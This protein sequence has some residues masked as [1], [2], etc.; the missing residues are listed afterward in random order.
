MILAATSQVA[1]GCGCGPA[2]GRGCGSAS[3]QG[4]KDCDASQNDIVAPTDHQ[5][6]PLSSRKNDR[7][8][9]RVKKVIVTSTLSFLELDTLFCQT[10]P[11]DAGVVDPRF[12][13][14]RVDFFKS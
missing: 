1:T 3:G 5:H 10:H 8:K 9:P 12:V 7:N 4:T 2:T 6:C 14:L 11:R 13:D